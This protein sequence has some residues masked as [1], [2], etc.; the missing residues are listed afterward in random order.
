MPRA[1]IPKVV[2]ANALLD[3]DV[4]WLAADGCW[5]RDM[6]QA[7]VLTD[8]ADAQLRLLE[9][10]AQTGLV[11]GA[12]LADVHADATG[13]RPTHFREEFR[14]RGPSNYPHGKQ[15]GL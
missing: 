15:A 13:P 1:F 4:V 3:G 8:E 10:L 14:R 5:T 9:A 12:Y 11:V 6:A 7:E 2:T